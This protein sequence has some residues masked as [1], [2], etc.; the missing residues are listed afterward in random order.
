MALD[1]TKLDAFVAASPG[2]PLK[3]DLMNEIK[4]NIQD[5]AAT[6]GGESGTTGQEI[7]S[8][9]V[10]YGYTAGTTNGVP[11]PSS[12]WVLSKVDPSL[13]TSAQLCLFVAPTEYTTVEE[14]AQ[15]GVFWADF[16]NAEEAS[17]CS[18]VWKYYFNLYNTGIAGIPLT[19]ILLLEKAP[20]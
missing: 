4:S 8:D 18:G 6:G 11:N 19:G 7:L 3:S 2:A 5:A 20:A 9:F 15:V 10:L 17:G 1:F 14:I 12:M 13:I 16:Q